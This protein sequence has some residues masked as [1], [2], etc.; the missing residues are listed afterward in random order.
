MPSTIEGRQA[1]GKTVARTK[2]SG[3][4][5]FHPAITAETPISNMRRCL[6]LR[7][8]LPHFFYTHVV[9]AAVNGQ[10]VNRQAAAEALRELLILKPDFALI[11]RNELGKWYPPELVEHLID[12]LRKA[13]LDA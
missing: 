6:A 8:N 7:I 3:S 11:G 4:W 9:I 5:Y 10:L 1:K 12:G 2:A 13:G